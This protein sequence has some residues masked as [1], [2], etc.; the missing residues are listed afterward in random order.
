M[1]LKIQMIRY[2]WGWVIM[3]DLSP[4]GLRSLPVFLRKAGCLE[5]MGASSARP[6]FPSALRLNC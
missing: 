1:K 6:R 3:V 2:F 4:L 5:V